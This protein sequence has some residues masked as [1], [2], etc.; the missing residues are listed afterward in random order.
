MLFAA[1]A[2]G[3]LGAGTALV[4]TDDI[5]HAYY[6]AERSGRVLST[7]MICINE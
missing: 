5:K 2:S 3:T 7:L 6:A 1:A 4:F